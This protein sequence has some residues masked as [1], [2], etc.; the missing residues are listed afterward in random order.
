MTAVLIAVLGF[1]A[2]ELYALRKVRFSE[3]SIGY[4]LD[5]NWIVLACNAIGTLMLI[6]L[7]PAVH[8]YF[9]YPP[10]L[11]GMVIGIM[12]PWLIRRLQKEVK[13][14]LK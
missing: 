9:A 4:Y 8:E 6:L 2:R 12:G 10:E 7:M 14:K 5:K 1:F 11:I 13:D 3:F